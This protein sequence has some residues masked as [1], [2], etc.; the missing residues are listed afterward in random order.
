MRSNDY[1]GESKTRNSQH[2][3]EINLMFSSFSLYKFKDHRMEKVKEMNQE[4]VI[5]SIS[6]EVEKKHGKQILLKFNSKKIKSYAEM[7]ISYY[8]KYINIEEKDSKDK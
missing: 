1:K 7:F 3:N 4:N 2:Q 5:E 8:M 6:Y